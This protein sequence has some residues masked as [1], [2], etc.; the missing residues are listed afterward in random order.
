M[1]VFGYTSAAFTPLNRD[2]GVYVS[3]TPPVL[4]RILREAILYGHTSYFHCFSSQIFS[5][6]TPIDGHCSTAR[7]DL[8]H[9]CS[10]SSMS[11]FVRSNE[12]RWGC[13]GVSVLM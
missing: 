4:P 10:Y 13:D 1:N 5:R 12:A 7:G 6:K 9:Y 3:S 11:P 2:L 8:V